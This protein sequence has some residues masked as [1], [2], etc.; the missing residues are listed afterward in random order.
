MGLDL[1]S[2]LE[3]M[4]LRV[5]D[6]HPHRIVPLGSRP[7]AMHDFGIQPALPDVDLAVDTLHEVFEDAFAKVFR[8]EGENDDFNQLVRAARMPADEIVVLRA[9]AKYMRQ[10]GFPLSQSFIEA[11]LAAHAG[12]ARMLVD[13]FK[14]RF[15]P[16]GG[17]GAG[18]RAAEHERAVE[19]AV[20]A[21]EV[22][23][24][25][26]GELGTREAGEAILRRLERSG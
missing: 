26:G 4:G 12:V 14:T 8:G 17:D 13:L 25:V 21:R 11:T 9:Y 18:S 5:L 1:R 15:D 20:Q 19:A 6:E 2:M 10:M 16:E 24:D 22:T 3:H 23:R 7:I